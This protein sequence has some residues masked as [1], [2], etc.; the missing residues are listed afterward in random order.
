MIRYQST[1]GQAPELSFEEV[2]LTG[3]AP[4]GGLYVP[5]E[6]PHFS[7]AEIADMARLSYPELAFKILSPFT[8]GTLSDEELKRLTFCCTLDNLL[9]GA[10]TQAI[11]NLNS[12]FGWDDHLGIIEL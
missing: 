7:P 2:V 4:D 6:L 9:K 3:L 12:A 8:E 10:A 1:R 5:N 11:Q